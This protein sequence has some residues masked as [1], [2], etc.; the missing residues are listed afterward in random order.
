[1]MEFTVMEV[2]VLRVATFLHEVSGQDN[3]LGIYEIFNKT[4]T[5][6]LPNGASIRNN[7]FQLF[8]FRHQ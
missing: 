7:M 2:T 8:I 3:F 1:M 4:I 6:K 5:I